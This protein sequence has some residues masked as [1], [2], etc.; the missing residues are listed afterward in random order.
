MI[1]N[2]AE[3]RT[4]AETEKL[5]DLVRA[6][7][8]DLVGV[9][10]AEPMP[11]REEE[12]CR[13]LSLGHHGEMTYLADH[14]SVKFRPDR[15]LPGVASVITVALNYY[16]PAGLDD[17]PSG[18]GG[19][20]D[21][22]TGAVSMYAWGRDYHKVIKR[23]LRSA[24]RQLNERFP[25]AQFRSFVD[26]LPIAER[27]YAERSG[28][29]FVGRNTLLITRAY[30]SWV[31]LGGILTTIGLAETSPDGAEAVMRCPS[32]CTRCIDACP[33]G[34]LFA[35]HRIDASKCIS[36]LTIER[37][38]R[39]DIGERASEE[40]LDSQ[41]G[42][43]VFGCDLCQRVCPFNLKAVPTREDDFT[44]WISGP[45]VEIGKIL[46]IT[47]HDEFVDEFAGSPLMRAGVRE[48]KRNALVAR[49]NQIHDR[50]H[51]QTRRGK[52]ED[53]EDAD[54]RNG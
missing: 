47:S 46:E 49:R 3:R 8:F 18:G 28:I 12:Y 40:A 51:D 1:E 34:A 32:G 14:A 52:D 31:F 13:W 6:C 10:S 27:H 17:A 41:T 16:Q 19:A 24:V 33:T 37:P 5:M 50:T 39:D 7:G 54:G 11:E 36:Y 23:R 42:D 38:V 25:R 29:G 9:T 44:R 2:P 48:M 30:G 4:R 15:L 45:R 35:P 21:S 20:A 53:R 22:E 43:W 26:L